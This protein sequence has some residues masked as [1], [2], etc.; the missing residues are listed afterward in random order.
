M[1]WPHFMEQIRDRHYHHQKPPT[2]A[3]H[4]LAGHEWPTDH[5]WP[6]TLLKASQEGPWCWQCP[7]GGLFHQHPAS[8]P[9]IYSQKIQGWKS[10]SR[11]E[12]QAEI[13]RACPKDVFGHTYKVPA[14]NPHKKY[15]FR[16]TRVG[17]LPEETYFFRDARKKVEETYFF[18][19]CP[20][21]TGRNWTKLEKTMKEVR[22][23]GKNNHHS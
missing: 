17:F 5:P 4:R 22:N 23:A 19:F 3:S 14:W 12:P 13:P 11:W 2:K 9:K 10:P 21:K 20:D 16:T 8:S 6:G 18:Q 15:D 1:Y 7:L